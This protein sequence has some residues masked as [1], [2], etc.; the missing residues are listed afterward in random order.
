[1]GFPAAGMVAVANTATATFS[2]YLS[3]ASARL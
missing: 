1:M 3:M 2:G